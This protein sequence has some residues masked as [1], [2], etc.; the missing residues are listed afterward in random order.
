ME[1]PLTFPYPP[2]TAVDGR[3]A[4]ISRQRL[5]HLVKQ[6][7]VRRVMR[8]VY[9]STAATDTIENRARAASL[10]MPPFAVV[11]DRTAA[12]IHGI[13]TVRYRELEMLPPLDVVVLRHSRRMD[14]SEWRNG[15]RDLAS[16]DV[17]RIGDI[18]VT[19]PLRTALDL[20]CKL[21]RT[22]ALAAVDQFMRV[23]G[24]S[25]D[26]LA[27]EL[28]RYFRRRG[29]VQLRAIVAVADPRSEAPSESWIRMIIIDAGLPPPELQYSV[30]VDGAERYRLDLAYPKHRICVEYDG[31]E[32][33][34][35]PQ[36]READRVRREW[37]RAAGWTVVVLTQADLRAGASRQWLDDL[38]SQLLERTPWPKG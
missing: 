29:V 13:D 22:D 10:V 2:F 17:M 4:G 33:H 36:D 3:E 24:L 6:R 5:R 14:R 19:T 38:R 23:H 21:S 35:S 20:G 1:S 11:C 26:D 34:T 15:E 30:V 28:P 32:F 7:Q 25:H 37:L 18:R 31:V 27:Q 9:Q 8:G 12:W 16:G